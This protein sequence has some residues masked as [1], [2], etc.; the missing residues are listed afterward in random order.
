MKKINEDYVGWSQGRVQGKAGTLWEGD[1]G[2]EEWTM[3]T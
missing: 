2:R 1:F 3:K